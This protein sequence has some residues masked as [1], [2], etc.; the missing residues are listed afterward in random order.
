MVK[1]RTDIQ[2]FYVIALKFYQLAVKGNNGNNI[3]VNQRHFLQF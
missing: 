1:C 3:E 2:V